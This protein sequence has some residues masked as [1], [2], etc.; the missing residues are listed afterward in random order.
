M[1]KKTAHGHQVTSESGKPL[2]GDD[3]TAAEAKKRLAQ[4]EYFK[5]RDKAKKR[6]G[7]S[8][9]AAKTG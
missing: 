4:V 1:I 8:R 7:L 3:L 2:S 5:H 6:G 9:W